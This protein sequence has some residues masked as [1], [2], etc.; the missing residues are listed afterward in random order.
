MAKN[1]IALNISENFIK[2]FNNLCLQ[3]ISLADTAMAAYIL[4][5]HC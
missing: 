4:K 2:N 5:C 1:I 3:L